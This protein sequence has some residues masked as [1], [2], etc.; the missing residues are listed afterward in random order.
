MNIMGQ[1]PTLR[2][3][4]ALQYLEKSQAIIPPHTTFSLHELHTNITISTSKEYRL[5]NHSGSS[6]IHLAYAVEVSRKFRKQQ[7]MIKADGAEC[8]CDESSKPVPCGHGKDS[9][10]KS[11]ITPRDAAYSA[12]SENYL[13]PRPSLHIIRLKVFVSQHMRRSEHKGT[14]LWAPHTHTSAKIWSIGR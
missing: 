2:W 1:N 12:G 13:A 8:V 7:K 6:D 9:I 5:D 10:S 4:H 14:H 11:S 3:T